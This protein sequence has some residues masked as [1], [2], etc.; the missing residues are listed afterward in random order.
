MRMRRQTFNLGSLGGGSVDAVA[1][2]LQQGI[3]YCI[4]N[5]GTYDPITSVAFATKHSYEYWLI[6]QALENLGSGAAVNDIWVIGLLQETPQVSNNQQQDIGALNVQGA[7]ALQAGMSN[8]LTPE[9]VLAMAQNYCR[10]GASQSQAVLTALG[11]GAPAPVPAPVP[12]VKA[13][14][15]IVTTT[16]VSNVPDI[17]S[18]APTAGGTLVT[19]P[20]L[21]S[22]G[23][24]TTPTAISMG[25]SSPTGSGDTTYAQG[26]QG[27]EYGGMAPS[28][29]SSS[30]RNGLPLPLLAL[31]LLAAALLMRKA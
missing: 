10:G 24:Q 19:K 30:S 14:I 7:H 18:S 6:S 4:A 5:N 16:A 28:T 8:L 13:Q 31:G 15:P 29:S 12:T 21:V 23:G 27:Q 25:V 20:Y 3:N 17:V 9:N 22:S 2:A 1:N 26:P 11:V